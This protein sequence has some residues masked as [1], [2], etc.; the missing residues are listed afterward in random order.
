M[1]VQARTARQEEARGADLPEGMQRAHGGGD[2]ARHISGLVDV[3]HDVREQALAIGLALDLCQARGRAACDERG[4]LLDR[5]VVREHERA[6]AER[7]GVRERGRPDRLLPDVGDEEAR[8]DALRELA[9]ARAIRGARGAAVHDP[10][11]G[12]LDRD[13]PAIRVL[14]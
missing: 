5:A 1:R 12:G 13:A 9:V 14:A 10:F 7:V 2:A 6:P 8:G 4:E 11:V 3:G